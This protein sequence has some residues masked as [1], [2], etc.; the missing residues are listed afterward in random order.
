MLMCGGENHRQIAGDMLHRGVSYHSP[1]IIIIIID[2]M[3]EAVWNP[4][5][6]LVILFFCWVTMRLRD[7]SVA[8]VF[9]NA[10]SHSSHWRGKKTNDAWNPSESS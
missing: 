2:Q 10:A 4:H 8:Y 6:Q 3:C 7:T 5:I 9:L 1:R